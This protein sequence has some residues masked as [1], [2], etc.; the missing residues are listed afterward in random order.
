[1]ADIR[2]L[3]TVGVADDCDDGAVSEGRRQG[4]G[5]IVEDISP[6]FG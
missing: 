4:P 6:N 3:A 2:F 1:M 5:M